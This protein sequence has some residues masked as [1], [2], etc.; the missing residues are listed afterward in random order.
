AVFIP[1][2][3]MEGAARSL[4]LPLSLAVG[5]SMVA[6]FILSSTFVP[7]LSCWILRQSGSTSDHVRESSFARFQR[8]Y[9]DSAQR[10]I[11]L[12]RPITAGY[13]VAAIILILF[14]GGR[15]GREIFPRVDAGQLQLRMHAPTGT[16]IERT[17]ELALQTLDQI[18]EEAG[19]DKVD[20]SLGFV[21]VQPS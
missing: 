8:K 17:E 12:R 7:V 21:G 1:S 2:F 14:V 16:R 6:S 4:F 13:V 10:I 15:L 20:V 18:K 19:Q 3:F 11:S 5:F 9:A